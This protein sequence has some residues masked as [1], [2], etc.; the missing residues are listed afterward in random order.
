MD[1]PGFRAWNTGAGGD[2]AV[3]WGSTPLE[4]A[5]MKL[6][7]RGLVS[8]V[9]LVFNI[10]GATALASLAWGNTEY[11][12]HV[13]FDN[14]LTSDA[15]FYSQGLANGSSSLELKNGHL[16]L[17]TKHFLTPTECAQVS[18]QSQAIAIWRS[19]IA[20]IARQIPSTSRATAL[21]RGGLRRVT[22]L[23]D[24]CLMRQT[25]PVIREL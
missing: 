20:R 5:V 12:R 22:D 15:Y 8:A 2:C 11:S 19:S 18:W 9:K 14:S 17:E 21:M 10:L 1:C 16:P 4:L 23:W 6:R 25:R 3:N 24:M 7:A 13:I